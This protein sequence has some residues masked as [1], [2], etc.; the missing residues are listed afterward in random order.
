MRIKEAANYFILHLDETCLAVDASN[1]TE[2]A[3]HDSIRTDPNASSLGPALKR[4]PLLP[5]CVAN[6]AAVSVM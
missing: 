4:P 3:V 2:T 6:S 1:V 5:V